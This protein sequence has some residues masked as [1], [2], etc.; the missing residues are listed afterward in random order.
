MLITILPSLVL[1]SLDISFNQ[2]G[3]QVGRDIC[4]SIS[5]N[6]NIRELSLQENNFSSE[7]AAAISEM[8][9]IS[10]ITA[11]DISCNSIG[12]VGCAKINAALQSNLDSPLEA[13][14][15]NENNIGDEGALAIASFIKSHRKVS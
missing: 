3:H 1:T 8:L 10:S 7:G 13:L 12:V 9:K 14:I 11:L 2:F 5:Q 4:K 6:V 15:L